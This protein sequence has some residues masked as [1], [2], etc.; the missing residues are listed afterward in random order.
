MARNLEQIASLRGTNFLLLPHELWLVR[1]DYEEFIKIQEHHGELMGEAMGQSSETYHD[2]APAEAVLHEQTV[3][4]RR[5]QPL[6]RIFRNHTVIDYPEQGSSDA[7]L[8]STVEVSINDGEPFGI[9]IVGYLDKR[10]ENDEVEQATYS[11]PLG[12]ALLGHSVGEIIDADIH[13]NERAL[14]IVGIDQ[15]QV[16]Q[17]Y[18]PILLE[19]ALLGMMGHPKF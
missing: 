6:Q 12:A 17:H 7:A 15:R 3:L 10:Y 9:Q 14:Q 18:A 13:G 19:S 2:N 1:R 5:V 4:M 8:G 16:V 11:S